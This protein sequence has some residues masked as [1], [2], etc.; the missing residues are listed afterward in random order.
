MNVKMKAFILL[1]V[2]L[3]VKPLSA[4]QTGCDF[5]PAFSAFDFWVGEWQ[6]FDNSSGGLSGSNNIEKTEAG[7]LILERWTA[8]RGG[9]GTSMNYFNPLTRQWR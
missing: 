5:E 8:T 9:T 2:L 7:Y 1:L 6:V 3:L 4:Q